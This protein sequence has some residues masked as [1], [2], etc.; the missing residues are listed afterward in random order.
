MM[1]VAVWDE[2]VNESNIQRAS[3]FVAFNILNERIRI[4]ARWHMHQ[5]CDCGFQAFNL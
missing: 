5:A 2:L 4:A 1:C 3:K